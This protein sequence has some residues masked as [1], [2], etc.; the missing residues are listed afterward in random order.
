MFDA[1]PE[2]VNFSNTVQ[3][4][5]RLEELTGCSCRNDNDNE[6]LLSFV[7]Y[8]VWWFGSLG[9]WRLHRW[10]C[11]WSDIFIFRL[12]CS[13]LRAHGVISTY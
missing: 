6:P 11:S 3:Y 2:T 9:F 1:K 7:E 13:F 8:A 10:S 5:Q 4:S 12:F